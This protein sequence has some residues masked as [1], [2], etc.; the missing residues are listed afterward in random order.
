MRLFLGLEQNNFYVPFVELDGI[1]QGMIFKRGKSQD[2]VWFGG[3]GD[4]ILSFEL[5]RGEQLI[6]TFEERPNTGN[7]KLVI[8]TGVKPG[9]NYRFRISDSKNRDEVVYSHPFEVKRKIPLGLKLGLSFALG[10]G[11]GI[12]YQKLTEPEYQIPD[13]MLPGQ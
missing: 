2:I 5:Y 12:L 6:R 13:P 8:P 11:A 10:V 4:N 7:T 1:E 3:R 9:N